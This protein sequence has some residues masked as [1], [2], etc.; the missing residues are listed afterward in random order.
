MKKFNALFKENI[1]RV[2][3]AGDSRWHLIESL[4]YDRKFAK[5]KGIAGHFQRAHIERFTNKQVHYE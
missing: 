3:I 4:H 1:T 5:L 2:K